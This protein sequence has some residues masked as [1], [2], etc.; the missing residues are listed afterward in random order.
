M[1]V[2]WP[3][4]EEEEKK[5]GGVQDV[6]PVG[7]ACTCR[8]VLTFRSLCEASEAFCLPWHVDVI[9]F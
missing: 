7:S 5:A 3:G 8:Y 9:V 6:P 2:L 4:C 1:G